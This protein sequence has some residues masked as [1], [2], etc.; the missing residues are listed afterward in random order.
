L[1]L[2]SKG[3]RTDRQHTP[4]QNTDEM[5]FPYIF[6]V[7]DLSHLFTV[8]DFSHLFPDRGPHSFD[9]CNGCSC[10]LA[11]ATP[12]PPLHSTRCEVSSRWCGGLHT[13]YSFPHSFGLWVI[14]GGFSQ[15]RSPLALPVS[16]L[17]VR[18]RCLHLQGQYLLFFGCWGVPLPL[19]EED[20]ILVEHQLH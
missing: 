9:H 7:R 3:Q 20:P 19:F 1:G 6:T 16:S 18:C 15:L 2:P 10:P 17:L 13:R 5:K 11:A 8:R 14:V 12:C 4:C